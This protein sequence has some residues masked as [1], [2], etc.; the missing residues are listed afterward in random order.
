MPVERASGGTSLIDVLDRV[1]DKGIVIDA[2]VR[3]SL[4]GIDLITVEARV[5]VAS[6]DLPPGNFIVQA[7]G[8][9][10]VATE[11]GSTSVDVNCWLEGTAAGMIDQQHVTV[12]SHTEQTTELLA[13]MT[14]TGEVMSLICQQRTPLTGVTI[15][16][17]WLVGLQV[18]PLLSTE[19]SV[20]LFSPIQ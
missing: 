7:K 17:A 14:T 4:V 10:S 12:L 18:A 9:V 15:D 16:N 2:W 8:Q 6:I 13:T 3:V 1:L 5:V 20:A 19:E 11:G